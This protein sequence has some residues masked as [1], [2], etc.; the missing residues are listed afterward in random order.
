MKWW[1]RVVLIGFLLAVVNVPYAAHVWQLHRAETDGVQV[2]AAVLKVT[3]SGD[4]ALVDFKMPAGV[5]SK[6]T[7]HEVKVDAATGA[8]AARTQQIRVQVLKGHPA[9][10]HVDGQIRSWTSAIVIGVADLLIL[11][12]VLLRWRLRG[13]FRR[14]ALEAVA[15]GDVESGEEG[16][17]LDK[18]ADGSYVINGEIAEAGPES[19]VITLRD[20]DVTVHLRG[21]RNQ[22]AVG[23]AAQVRAHLVG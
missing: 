23:E 12:M 7:V 6:Q 16:S 10:F 14:P 4:D 21:Y 1:G 22:V 3:P 11:V 17:L 15:L 13:R 9:V 2:T 8:A 18:Q 5:D 19:M 20:R